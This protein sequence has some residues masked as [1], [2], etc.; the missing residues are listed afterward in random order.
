MPL[1]WDRYR[2]VLRNLYLTD[3]ESLKEIMAIM[4]RKYGFSA[5]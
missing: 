2:E 1:D 5:T 3:D 4:E